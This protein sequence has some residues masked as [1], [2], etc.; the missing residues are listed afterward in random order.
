MMQFLMENPDS[1]AL[2]NETYQP[3]HSGKYSHEPQGMATLYT[4]SVQAKHYL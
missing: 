4:S 2:Y 1:L 3:Q